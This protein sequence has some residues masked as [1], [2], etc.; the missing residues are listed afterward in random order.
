MTVKTRSEIRADFDRETIVV[1]QAY[2]PEIAQAALQ[3]GI[4]VPPFSF[5][6]MKWIKPS[7]YHEFT[8]YLR[9]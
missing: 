2:K 3:A 6:R 5:G 9:R 4:F 8:D 7:S 1:Y